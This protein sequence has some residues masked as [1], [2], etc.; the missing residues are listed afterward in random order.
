[1][2]WKSDVATTRSG[3]FTLADIA[4]FVSHAIN[5]D[6]FSLHDTVRFEYDI[7]QM[8]VRIVVEQR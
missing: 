4:R 3:H 2:R 1:M 6:G 8:R 7:V 5:N